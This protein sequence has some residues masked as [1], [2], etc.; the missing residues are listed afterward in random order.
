M[1]NVWNYECTPIGT[2]TDTIS[3]FPLVGGTITYTGVMGYCGTAGANI[4]AYSNGCSS[5]TSL[6]NQ[7]T[8]TDTSGS[9]IWDTITMLDSASLSLLIANQYILQITNLDNNCTSI[10]TFTINSGVIQSS[11][12]SIN[13]SSTIAADG[14]ITVTIIGGNSP[15]Q[16]WFN[17]G[18]GFSQIV[19]WTNGDP[20]TG[21]SVGSYDYW[22]TDSLGCQT[23]NTVQ[24]IYNNCTSTLDTIGTCAPLTLSAQ[25]TNTLSGTY[26]YTYNS[27]FNR[28]F[29]I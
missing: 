25:I 19:G 26:N 24:I 1:V 27:S 15:Y 16:M 13:T 6:G 9:L 3:V 28:K 4:I 23:Q 12:T 20:I 29:R 10:D 17:D 21:L 14:S 5:P 22:V 2:N 8:L 11:Y 18:T 7:F